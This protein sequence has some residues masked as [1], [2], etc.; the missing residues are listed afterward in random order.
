M[1]E[2]TLVH[3]LLRRSSALGM[4]LF[5]NNVGRLRVDGRWIQ[6]GLCVGSSDLIGWTPVV[7]TP[8]HVGRT[9]LVFTAVEAKVGRNEATPEQVR[10][11]GAVTLQ[12]GIAVLARAESDLDDAVESA[13]GVQ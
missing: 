12:G 1:T 3:R 11:L 8:A 4:R 6:Y 7:I 10:F 2:T 9:L 5:R 13:R